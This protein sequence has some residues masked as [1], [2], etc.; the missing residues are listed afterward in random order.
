[1]TPPFMRLPR[2]LREQI[3]EL[4]LMV[5][6]PINPYPAHFEKANVFH[7][8]DRKPDIFL[9]NVNKVINIEATRIV[10]SK[11]TFRLTWKAGGDPTDTS[12]MLRAMP[13]TI[14]ITQRAHLKHIITDFD[15]RDVEPEYLLQ[16]AK[17][18]HDTEQSGTHTPIIT[19]DELLEAMHKER[20]CRLLKICHW[21]LFFIRAE[22]TPKTC[23]ISL[24]HLYCPNGCCR[25]QA[26][27]LV[28]GH[29]LSRLDYRNAPWEEGEC[30]QILTDPKTKY[31]V[32]GLGAQKERNMLRRC[33]RRQVRVD[34]SGEERNAEISIWF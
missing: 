29:L 5:N 18:W 19:R 10:Y 24:E 7:T 16:S 30:A 4:C 1:M 11:N 12:T 13:D 25:E 17:A 27:Q 22:C 21:K 20:F 32:T 28:C 2:E 23:V 6:G 15:M 26:V 14:W 31:T 3:L 8:T 33:W 34:F 9:L